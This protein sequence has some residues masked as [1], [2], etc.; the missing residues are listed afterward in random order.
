MQV[1]KA[2]RKGGAHGHASAPDCI[3]DFGVSV[4]HRPGCD[5]HKASPLN[6]ARTGAAPSE[7][8]MA[9]S[10]D[11]DFLE[12]RRHCAQTASPRGQFAIGV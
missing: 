12:L 3:G 7:R 2:G 9:G 10:S 4:F 11:S 8:L 5:R 1:I 6:Q